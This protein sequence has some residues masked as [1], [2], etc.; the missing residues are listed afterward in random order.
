MKTLTL[1]SYATGDSQIIRGLFWGRVAAMLCVALL[2]LCLSGCVTGKGL[3]KALANLKDDPATVTLDITGW[4]VNI[5]V[6]R[7]N[8]NTNTPPLTAGGSSVT[9]KGATP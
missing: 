4:G 8:P 6:T 9:V 2:A 5:K 3:A 7:T 1:R